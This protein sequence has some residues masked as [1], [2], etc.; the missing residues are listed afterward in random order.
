MSDNSSLT[1]VIRGLFDSARQVIYTLTEKGKD[2]IPA[3]L[4]LARRGAKHVACSVAPKNL[5]HRIKE[6]CVGDDWLITRHPISGSTNPSAKAT[7]HV[8]QIQLWFCSQLARPQVA[9][10]YYPLCER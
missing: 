6:D 10:R 9:T 8:A 5:A 2:L 4:E 3:L 1:R 7:T